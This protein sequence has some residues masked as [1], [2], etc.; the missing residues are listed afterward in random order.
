MTASRSMKN[1]ERYTALLRHPDHRHRG[2][3]VAPSKRYNL[4]ARPFRGG[5]ESGGTDDSPLRRDGGWAH[6]ARAGLRRA[7]AKACGPNPR[8]LPGSTHVVVRLGR[9][10]VY[11]SDSDI[12]IILDQL[13][14]ERL[15]FGDLDEIQSALEDAL[16][17]DVFTLCRPR[18]RRAFLDNFDRDRVSVYERAQRR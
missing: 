11:R 1:I 12:D 3:H 14:G 13:E 4:L 2:R 18:A 7:P 16:G 10:G 5:G 15:S 6:Q 9:Q 17:V 8:P